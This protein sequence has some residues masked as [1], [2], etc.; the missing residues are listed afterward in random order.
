M[1][2]TKIQDHAALAEIFI[3]DEDRVDW[4]DGALWFIREKRDIASKK[5]P[6]WEELREAAS[7]IKSNVIS[8]L[9]GYLLQFEANLKKNGIIVHWADDAEEHNEIVYSILKAKE[10]NQMVKSKS[11]LTEECHLNEYLEERGIEFR[12]GRIYTTDR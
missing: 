7:K 12:P 10:I 9:H 6:E 5:I 11:M 8:N 3:K 4:H 2:Q 1:N